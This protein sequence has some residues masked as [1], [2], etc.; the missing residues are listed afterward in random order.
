MQ[1]DG[2]FKPGTLYELTY[3]AKDP[4]V[5]GA[6]LA[7]IR[8]LLA[9]FRDHPFAG[10]PAPRQILIFGISQSGRLIGRMLHDGLDVDET[11]RLAFDGAYM[12]VPGGGGGRR[13][14]QPLRAAD[15]PSLDARRARLSR[16]RFSVHL[17]AVA[18]SCHRRTASIAR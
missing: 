17:R 15:A 14:Q 18:R 4:Y 1:L 2:G 9:Y 8:D 13:L 16:G 6:G 3:V 10:A 12:E 5:T 11:G 7:G